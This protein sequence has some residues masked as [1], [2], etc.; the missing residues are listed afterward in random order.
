MVSGFLVSSHIRRLAS[1]HMPGAS[2]TRPQQVARRVLPG[3]EAGFVGFSVSGDLSFRVS[4]LG[5]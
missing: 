2:S 3:S 4:G 5:V 1:L